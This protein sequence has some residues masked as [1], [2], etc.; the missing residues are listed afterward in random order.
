LKIIFATQPLE[1]PALELRQHV[2]FPWVVD[3]PTHE[4][5]GVRARDEI[6]DDHQP[7]AGLEPRAG[8]DVERLGEEGDHQRSGDVHPEVKLDVIVDQFELLLFVFLGQVFGPYVH[9]SPP[10]VGR[11]RKALPDGQRR[12]ENAVEKAG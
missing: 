12:D 11:T 2:L 5:A 1:G 9:R 4:Q 7:E 6:D 10:A 3:K 8:F